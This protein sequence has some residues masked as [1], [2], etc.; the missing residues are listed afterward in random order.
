MVAAVGSQ[1]RFIDWLFG[2]QALFSLLVLVLVG[3]ALTSEWVLVRIVC[4]WIEFKKAASRP[5]HRA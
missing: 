3:R 4:G 5:F 1:A 2:D